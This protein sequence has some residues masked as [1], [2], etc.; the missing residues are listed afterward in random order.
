MLNDDAK[1][2]QFAKEEISKLNLLHQ[3][4]SFTYSKSPNELLR[5]IAQLEVKDLT[6]E[7]PTLEDIFMHY[8]E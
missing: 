8:Y 6:I 4:V 3:R 2:E 1:E 5:F 7:E